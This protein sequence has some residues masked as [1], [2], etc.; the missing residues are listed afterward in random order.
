MWVQV[1]K[2]TPEVSGKYWC[3]VYYEGE[4]MEGHV[5]YPPES[6]Q[7]VFDVIVDA[8]GISGS[9]DHDEVW[10]EVVYWWDQPL[11]EMPADMP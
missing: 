10:E 2:R 1:D 7:T 5:I 4:T 6:Y 3:C 9:G 8:D 11:P